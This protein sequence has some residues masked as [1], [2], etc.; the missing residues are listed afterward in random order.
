M[1]KKVS[2]A[3]KLSVGTRDRLRQFCEDRGILQAHFVE[4]AI[5]ERL[6]RENSSKMRWNSSD[7]NTRSRIDCPLTTT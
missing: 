4:Q 6:D 2:Y 1:I 5:L 3:F 7:G